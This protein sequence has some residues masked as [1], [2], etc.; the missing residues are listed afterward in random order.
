MNSYLSILIRNHISKIKNA[1]HMSN[2]A[3]CIK[4][5][6]ICTREKKKE[7]LWSTKKRKHGNEKLRVTLIELP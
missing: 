2:S 1:Y 7:G 4:F 5:K 6:I 3:K